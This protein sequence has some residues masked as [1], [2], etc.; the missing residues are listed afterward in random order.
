MN[1]K[2]KKNESYKKRYM[3]K[4][5]MLTALLDK[6]KDADIIEWLN[7]QENRSEAIRQAIRD[8]ITY[9]EQVKHG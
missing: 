4:H 7:K 3:R 1:N 2:L 9:T 6:E 5:K 8:R